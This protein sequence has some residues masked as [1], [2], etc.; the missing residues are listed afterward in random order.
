MPTDDEIGDE[1]V[2][3]G[4][5]SKAGEV[6]PANIDHGVYY[7]QEAIQD[8]AE[9][10]V[11]S[12]LRLSHTVL[13]DVEA[14]AIGEVIDFRTLE[15]K[16]FVQT[17]LRREDWDNFVDTLN[18]ENGNIGI[19]FNQLVRE[20]D[21]G[22]LALSAG[23]SVATVPTPLH[24]YTVVQIRE[25]EEVSIV[26]FPAS[27]ASWAWGCDEACE[28]V[29]GEQNMA[30]PE[31]NGVEV[32]PSDP[33]EEEETPE[34]GGDPAPPQINEAITLPTGGLEAIQ[35]TDD[36]DMVAVPE[37]VDPE[38]H[39]PCDE[40]QSLEQKV[41]QLEKERDQYKEMLQ[42]IEQERRQEAGGRLREINQELPEEQ[43]YGEEELE[44]FIEDSSAE[45]LSQ[46]A[47]MLERVASNNSTPDLEQ[48]Q[49]DLSGAS[50]S[51]SGGSDTTD[52]EDAKEQV[53]SVSQ[54]L[55]GKDIEEMLEVD[56][57]QR[58]EA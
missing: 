50:G 22:N 36:G 52:P 39:G 20:V 23:L 2:F 10:I 19:S 28:V 12:P 54:S 31:N 33:G 14:S 13:E 56:E 16:L 18:N 51:G 21:E 26:Q 45:H 9:D 17:E 49:E 6:L 47:D 1:Y 38:Q 44:E 41:E 58:G 42:K 46:T 25:W 24:P 29:F 32:E 8:A 55:W 30:D 15:D 57:D 53:N 35:F 7:T 37:G 5:V 27:P 48:G 34:Q 4:I 40:C 3:W 43:Q 11:G